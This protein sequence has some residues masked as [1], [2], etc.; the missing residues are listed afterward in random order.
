MKPRKLFMALSLISA[1]AKTNETSTPK[2]DKKPLLAVLLVISALQGCVGVIDKDK[3]TIL[4]S[5]VAGTI[6]PL[7][8]GKTIEGEGG[9]SI[10]IESDSVPYE[11]QVN[12]APIAPEDLVADQGKMVSV[13]AVEVLFQP[14]QF[15]PAYVLPPSAALKISI[16]APRKLPTDSVILVVQQVLTDSLGDPEKKTKASLKE[17]FVAVGTAS[18][19]KGKIVTQSEGPL[20]G[21]FSGGL[22]NFLVLETGF[23]TGAVSDATGPRPGVVTVSNNTNTIVAITDAFGNYTLPISGPC[24]CAFTVTGFDPFRGSSGSTSS[25]VPLDGAT[26]NAD[27]ALTPLATPAVTRDG[28]RNGGF[29]RGD[30]TSWGQTGA[31]A[32]RQ[33]L[34]STG[35]TINPTEGQWMADISTGTGSIGAIGA[36]LRQTFTVP[37]GVQTLSFDFNFVSEE[38]PE[39]VGSQYNDAFTAV[40][41]TPNEIT[42]ARTSVNAARN[43]GLIGDC[44]FP[45]GDATCGQTGWLQGNVNLSAFS[46]TAVPIQLDLIFSAIDA[47]D[48]IYDTHVLVDNMRFSTVFIDAKF[49]QGPTIAAN[50][51]L[52][53]VQ[54]EV[55]GANEILSQAGVNVQI[56]NTRTVATTDALVDTDITWTTIGPGCAGGRQNGILTAESAAVLALARSATATDVNVYYVRSLTGNGGTIAY[57]PGPDDFCVAINILVNSGVFIADAGTGSGILAHELGHLLIS[58]QNAGNVLEHSAAAGNFMISAAPALGIVNRQQSANINRAGAPLLLP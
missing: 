5:R 24:P 47:G 20:P 38:F 29:E 9:T 23:A 10:T 26:A 22:F 27:L 12:I 31:A 8:V 54:N 3:V 13:G 45:G 7:G 15:S 43:V 33:S 32:A 11:V 18:V 14:T 49:L 28:I 17:Q 6:V 19:K 34:V 2:F 35:A 16:P 46:G 51:N 57:A 1:E 41:T 36:S 21:V 44:N 58:P 52:A 4:P 50:A 37:A 53:R 30:L 42:F 25:T 56:R 40:V 55:L 48:N 39:W